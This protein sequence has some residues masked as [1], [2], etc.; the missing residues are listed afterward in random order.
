MTGRAVL[1]LLLMGVLDFSDVGA[2]ELTDRGPGTNH[3]PERVSSI[4]VA[5][6]T[7]L[8]FTTPP[9]SE[10]AYS[11]VFQVEEDEPGS[12]LLGAVV[13]AVATAV[14]LS[15]RS[16]GDGGPPIVPLGALMGG[17]IFWSAG[18]G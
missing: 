18:I 2:Q 7:F 16:G 13:G 1:G 12:F 11:P 4:V 3:L 8:R 6:T 5:D 10:Q 9:G 15:N 17:I 14:Y